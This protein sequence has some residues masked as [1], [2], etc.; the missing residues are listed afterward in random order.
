MRDLLWFVWT[1]GIVQPI[2]RLVAAAQ[3]ISRLVA[4]AQ[5]ISRL[6]A[7]AQPISRLLAAAQPIQPVGGRNVDHR[8]L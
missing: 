8:S 6:L 1:G 5:P 4:A 3:P 7:A 2:S